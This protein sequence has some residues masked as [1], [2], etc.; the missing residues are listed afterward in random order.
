MSTFNELYK[1]AYKLAKRKVLRTNV[2]EEG[3]VG[4]AIE[5]KKWKIYSGINL[6]WKCAVGF[7][8][9]QSAIADMLKEG[10][11]EIK[12]L[13]AVHEGGDI[14]APCGVCREMIMQINPKNKETIVFIGKDERVK[15]ELLLPEHWT[16]NLK[17]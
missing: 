14:L 1:I 11:S 10:E 7:C 8:A 15:L 6:Q 4:C 3:S 5:S 2:F 13:V 9:E 16:N 12:K 17:R